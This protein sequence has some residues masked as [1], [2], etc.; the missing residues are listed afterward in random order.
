[1]DHDALERM[2]DG[3]EKPTNLSFELLKNITDS[4]SEERVIGRGG[5]GIV[6]KVIITIQE[7]NLYI[8]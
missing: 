1:M 3:R 2:L 5:F 7:N 6:Y 4:F 8:T